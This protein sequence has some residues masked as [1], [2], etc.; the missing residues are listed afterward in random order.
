M[1]CRDSDGDGWSDPTEDWQAAPW[2]TGDA[3]PNDRFQ[4]LDADEDG[5]GDNPLGS[6]RDDCPEVSGSS[7]RDIQGCPDSDGDGWSDEYGGFASA[8]AGLGENPAGSL[9][10]YMLLGGAI[11]L[12]ALAAAVVRLLRGDQSFNAEDLKD[13]SVYEAVYEQ[14]PAHLETP[15]TTGDGM[16]EIIDDLFQGGDGNA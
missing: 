6:A 1:G 7:T 15:Q 12:G 5:F 13:K 16:Y 4:W 9:L 2:G 14:Q 11:M 8:I 10:S 3:F